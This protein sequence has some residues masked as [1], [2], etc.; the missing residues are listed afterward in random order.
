MLCHYSVNLRGPSHTSQDMPCQDSCSAATVR[1]GKCVVAAVADGLGSESHS[2]VGSSVAADIAVHFVA[3]VLDARSDKIDRLALI[4]DAY[5]AAYDAVLDGA[6]RLG[7]PAGQFDCTLTLAVFEDGHLWWGHSGDS[8]LMV[9]H[10]DGSYELV[11]TMQRDDEG[12]VYPLCFD[13]RWV[14]GE[15]S[16]VS[17]A[18]LCTDGVLE[19]LAPSVLAKL[20]DQPVDTKLARMFLH[21]LEGDAE[22]LD[23][24]ETGARAYWDAYPAKS[25]DDD[26]T[27]VVVFD[28]ERLPGEREPGYYAGPDWAEVGH[29]MREAL[30]SASAA[31]KSE[32]A[33]RPEGNPTPEPP[34]QA[35]PVQAK[36]SEQPEPAAAPKPATAPKVAPGAP[37]PRVPTGKAL[38]QPKPVVAPGK[39]QVAGFVDKA[40]DIGVTCAAVTISCGAAL[41]VAVSAAVKEIAAKRGATMPDDDRLRAHKRTDSR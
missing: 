28:T 15:T 30:Y 12:R 29:L 4:R 33:P 26:K 36:P 1:E 39:G 27:L 25:L 21:P 17:T 22:H 31:A 35:K 24:V 40:I 10:E 11:T 19:T 13:N 23:E 9:A 37:A 6:D 20:T 38:Y 14:F 18:L 16:D 32:D 3:T 34:S 7:E 2:D 41:G 8:G 5:Y